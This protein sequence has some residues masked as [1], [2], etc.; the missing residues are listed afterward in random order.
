MTPPAAVL[1]EPEQ[2]VENPAH[3]ARFVVLPLSAPPAAA[4]ECSCDQCGRQEFR[5][6]LSKA[7]ARG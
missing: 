5:H 1:T 4:R 6:V 2:R 3:G 7:S